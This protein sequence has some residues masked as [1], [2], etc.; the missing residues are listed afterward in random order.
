MKELRSV[1][2]PEPFVEAFREAEKYVE[3]WYGSFRQDPT[4]GVITIGGERY[5]LVRA[6]SMS[7]HFT[8]HIRS[9]YPG[10]DE[11]E[12]ISVV[13]RLLFDVV[14]GLFVLHRQGAP[15]LSLGG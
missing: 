8:E 12:S 4:Q 15:R 11:D 1:S 10:L 6:A 13:N 9:M 5:I 7:V 14:D 3:D 2:V